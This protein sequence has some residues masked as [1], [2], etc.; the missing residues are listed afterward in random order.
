MAEADPGRRIRIDLALSGTIIDSD[1]VASPATV[2]DLS[3]DGCRIRTQA[4]LYEGEEVKLK[5]GKSD[6]ASAK[7]RWALGDEAGLHFTSRAEV[8]QG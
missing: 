6:P 1:G 4:T 2:R 5:V 8:P 3:K 7:V